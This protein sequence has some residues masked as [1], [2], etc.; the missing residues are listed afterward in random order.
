MKKILYIALFLMAVLEVRGQQQPMYSQYYF[1]ALSV[2]PAYAGSR[3][4]LTLTA[5]FRRQWLGIQSAPITQTISAHAPDYSRRN[6]FGITL[7][8]DKISYLGQTWITGSYAYRINMGKHKLAFGLNGTIFNW[9]IN[10]AKAV[11]IDQL[12]E[13][14]GRYGDSYWMPNVGAGVFFYGP[15][16]YLGVSAPHLLVNSF[17]QN[18]PTTSISNGNSSIAALR[19]HLFFMGGYVFDISKDFQLKPSTLVKQVY[20]AP[21]EADFNL[22]AYIFQKFGFGVSYRTG[23][24]IVGILEYQFTNQLR[25]GYAYDYPFTDLRKY[26]SGSHELMLSYEFHYKNDA[27]VSPRVF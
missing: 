13:V 27:V 20:G 9:R 24:G 7:V 10:W 4:S 6:G 23:D 16:A 26:T 2:N 19:R 11:L 5:L 21:L 22:N 12:D 25:A 18:G 14:P 15:R 3:E 17:G 8:N 1:N